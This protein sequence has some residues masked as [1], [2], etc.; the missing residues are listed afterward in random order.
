[1]ND[2]ITGIFDHLT[3]DD[4]S[5][6][7]SAFHEE[8]GS[9]KGAANFSAWVN[10]QLKT[11]RVA[12]AGADGHLNP[13]AVLTSPTVTRSFIPDDDETLGDFLK[14]LGREARTIGATWFFLAKKAFVGTMETTEPPDVS[15]PEA[16]LRLAD[17]GK[18]KLGV[19]WYAE[20]REG[21]ER[22]QR[23]GFLTIVENRLGESVEGDA[24]QSF[25][26]LASVLEAV[27][28]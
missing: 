3:P 7:T 26:A 1:V 24:P 15:D 21:D 12:F 11:L 8:Q 14:R 13:V 6:E 9:F 22:H 20:R 19:L 2:N 17:E 18:L 28:S 4:F 10:G 25:A 5:R 16:V 23:T 27:H